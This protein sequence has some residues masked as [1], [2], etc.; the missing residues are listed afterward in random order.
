MNV[1]SSLKFAC[2]TKGYELY[3]YKHF[4]TAIIIVVKFF[5]C[6]ISDH[7]IHLNLIEKIKS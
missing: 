4:I 1:D 5:N 2:D 3:K 7:K 6:E